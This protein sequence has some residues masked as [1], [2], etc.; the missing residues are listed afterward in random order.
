MSDPLLSTRGSQCTGLGLPWG[1]GTGVG[2]S[3]TQNSVLCSLSRV[4]PIYQ[5]P[6]VLFCLGSSKLD[7]LNFYN[8]E[9]LC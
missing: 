1:M 3:W 2:W 7:N 8:V 4:C 5:F 9:R 6:V